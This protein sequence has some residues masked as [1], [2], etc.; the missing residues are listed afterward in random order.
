MASLP[1]R[2]QAFYQRLSREGAS[3]LDELFDLYTDDVEFVSPIEKRIGIHAFRA[4]WAQAF[5][6]YEAFTFT[7]F[8][9]VGDDRSFALFY[10]MTIDIG[11]GNP[12]PT[13]TAT[14]FVVREGKVYYQFDYWDT[15]GG[16]AQIYPPLKAAYDWAVALLLGGGKPVERDPDVHVPQRGADGCYHPSSEAE[17]AALV[18]LTRDLGGKIR[19]V[20][21]GHSVW[22]AIVPEGFDPDAETN[23]RLVCLDRYG[24]ILGFRDDPAQPGYLLVE[25]EAGC[26][27][28]E[29]PRHPVANPLS[30]RVRR[31]IHAPRTSP[32]PRAGS[33]ASASPC[34][35][36][37]MR[38]PTSVESPTRRSAASS[39]RARRAA[40]ANGRSSTRSCRSA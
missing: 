22:E 33:R 29:S 6:T 14:L 3:A 5:E 39:P 32:T 8:K 16:L 19:V 21:S 23:E 31:A 25:V 27:L 30:P 28:G 4:S 17:L 26:H 37:G 40:P 2:M 13:P 36:A 18:R 9:C 38:C 35:G 34:S 10:T 11:V 20:G 1:A 7:D 15:V 24:R 12:M